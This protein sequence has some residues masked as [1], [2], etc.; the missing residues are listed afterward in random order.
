MK[1]YSA[2][3]PRNNKSCSRAAC[4]RST[5]PGFVGS[6]GRKASR[7]SPTDL[8]SR[9]KALRA[10]RNATAPSRPPKSEFFTAQR[11]ASSFHS[12]LSSSG[13]PKSSSFSAML[14]SHDLPP[15]GLSQRDDPCRSGA[16]REGAKVKP[17][18]HHRKDMESVFAIIHPGIK[19]R[20][21][22]VPIQLRRISQRQ[23]MLRPVHHILRL[24]PFELHAPDLTRGVVN[25]FL[26]EGLA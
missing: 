10:V 2:A 20:Q 15:I 7:S 8:A 17:S 3:W 11:K 22:A 5:K 24:V 9:K 21:A 12:G 23:P 25:Q 26:P 4:A 16:S 19:F 13:T 6:N 18:C 14:I 1:G